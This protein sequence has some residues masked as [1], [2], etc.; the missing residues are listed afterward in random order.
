MDGGISR[1]Y[2]V[3]EKLGS[4]G[5]G[6][7]WKAI[8]RRTKQV[9][10][11][12]RVAGVL[13]N[14]RSAQKIYREVEF[15]KIF[16]KHPNIISLLGVHVA[17]NSA[18]V[19]LALEF[20]DSDL[21]KFI[22]DGQLRREYIP[23]VMAQLLQGMQFVH[24]GNIIHRDLKPANVLINRNHQARISDFGLARSIKS[25]YTGNDPDLTQFCGT[26]WYLAPEALLGS[27]WYTVSVD[28]WSLGLILGEMLTGKPF[29][30]G[31]TH[32]GVMQSIL[33][34]IPCPAPRDLVRL[35][36]QHA[37]WIHSFRPGQSRPLSRILQRQPQEA[38]DLVIRLLHIDPNER[39]TADQALRHPCVASYRKRS[40]TFDRD[41]MLIVPDTVLLQC[42]EYR[43]HIRRIENEMENM[44][45]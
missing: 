33:A 37:Q 11:L 38:A 13:R 29:F 45:R 26:T 36:P 8:D 2:E 28:M 16:S 43:D 40:L 7:V 9:I 19:Y 25:E 6:T 10:A 44:K 12:K 27:K 14:A 32:V 39:P 3:K 17:A 35:F 30:T 1:L 23:A 22:R 18:D 24:S 34:S 15:V 20:M 42:G 31:D 41:V 21:H 4:G 5:F